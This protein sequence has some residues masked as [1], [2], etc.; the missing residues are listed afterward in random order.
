MLVM[1]YLKKNPHQWIQT[2]K[3][4]K[5][6]GLHNSTVIRAVRKLFEERQIDKR[7]NDFLLGRGTFVKY[8]ATEIRTKSKIEEAIEETNTYMF[9]WVQ[10]W[11]KGE[12]K[13]SMDEA[14]KCLKNIGEG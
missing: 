3:I 4:A 13:K 9:Q 7:I 1:N 10:K 8:P 5:E 11:F 2:S 12:K 14:I 6:L